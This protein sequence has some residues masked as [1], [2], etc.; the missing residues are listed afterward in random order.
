MLPGIQLSS[1]GPSTSHHSPS[2]SAPL[3]LTPHSVLF[4]VPH[5]AHHGPCKS[6]F[7]AFAPA[8]GLFNKSGGRYYH[9]GIDAG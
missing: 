1:L 7:L 9:R 3:L 6:H 8:A 2:S 5:Y 4:C